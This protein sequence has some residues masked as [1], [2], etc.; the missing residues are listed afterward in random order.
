MLTIT[1]TT[2]ITAVAMPVSIKTSVVRSDIN[3]RDETTTPTRFIISTSA[4]ILSRISDYE[5]P[6]IMCMSSSRIFFLT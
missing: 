2:A 5:A 1:G 3:I 6:Q 4:L